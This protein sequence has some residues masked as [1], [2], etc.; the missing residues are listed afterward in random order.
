MPRGI[1][2]D[3]R[4]FLWKVVYTLIVGMLWL[5]VNLIAGIYYELGIVHHGISITNIVYYIF[6]LL[7]IAALLWYYYKVWKD[8]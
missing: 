6:L 5:F 2:P 4:R 3:I 7:S 1:E 8:V